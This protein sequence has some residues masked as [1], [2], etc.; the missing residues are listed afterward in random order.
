MR[1]RSAYWGVLAM[2][3]GIFLGVTPIQAQDDD[4]ADN[5]EQATSVGLN[6]STPGELN[7]PSDQDFFRIEVPRY[8]Q[9]TVTLRDAPDELRYENLYGDI[10]HSTTI[11]GQMENYETANHRGCLRNPYSAIG[12]SYDVQPG[13]CV[14]RVGVA[15]LQ[16]PSGNFLSPA[17]YTL[18]VRF[19]AEQSREPNDPA[20]PDVA[21]RCG[22]TDIG[23]SLATA[24]DLGTVER[25]PNGEETI[26]QAIESRCPDDVDVYRFTVESPVAVSIEEGDL[27]GERRILRPTSFDGNDGVSYALFD[28]QGTQISTPAFSP[29]RRLPPGEFYLVVSVAENPAGRGATGRYRLDVQTE[30]S[31]PEIRPTT[32]RTP[33]AGPVAV[34]LNLSPWQAWVHLYCQKDR[35]ASDADTVNPCT[36]RF[37]CNGMSGEPVAWNVDVPPKTIFSYWPNKTVD[38]TE[39][40]LQAALMEAGKTEEEARRR[41]TCEV[42][43]SDPV[44]VRG[45][46]LF[47]GQ[48]TLVPVAV[49]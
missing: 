20:T 37:E 21:G 22:D 48:P 16:L 43:S 27:A 18:H 13:V 11:S 35:S 14:I 4:H 23:D 25:W 45:Y 42:F 49:Y 24:H 40:D 26:I 5:N 2:C 6:S 38:G 7:Y 28:S 47:G 30:P 8:G 31:F 12:P 39:A 29:L 32:G 9:V 1:V 15:R 34:L 46:T 3:L 33:G 41:T 10:P 17:T 44:A 19:T 36:V